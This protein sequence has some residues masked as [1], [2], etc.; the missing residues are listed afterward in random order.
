VYCLLPLGASQKVFSAP[1]FADQAPHDANLEY[2]T[3]TMV[4][5]DG[6]WDW[7]ILKEKTIISCPCN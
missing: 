4:S 5:N 7:Q 3:A 1:R 6:L 2:R